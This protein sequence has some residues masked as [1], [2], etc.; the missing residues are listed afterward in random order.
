MCT[1]SRHAHAA[2]DQQED[3]AESAVVSYPHAV[4]GEGICAFI[5][6]KDDVHH[7]RAEIIAELKQVVRTNIAAYAVPEWILVRSCVCT[8]VQLYLTA[9][10]RL[11]PACRKRAPVSQRR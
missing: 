11:Y 4:K 5:I 10:F 2:Q 7:K 6:L 8:G 9:T 3:V 1:P